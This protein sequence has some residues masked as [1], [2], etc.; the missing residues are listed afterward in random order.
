MGTTYYFKIDIAGDT[1]RTA[2]KVKT[3]I[4]QIDSIIDSLLTQALV[5]IGNGNVVEYEIDTGQS[6]QKVKLMDGNAVYN[7]INRYETLRQRYENMLT[8]RRVRLV[9]GKNF[10]YKNR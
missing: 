7:M 9:D 1:G 2:A 3:I 10:R 5:D 6:K 4:T 8:P